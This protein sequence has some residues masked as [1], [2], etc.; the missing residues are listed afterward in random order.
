LNVRR[1]SILNVA[2]YYLQQW[3]FLESYSAEN[4]ELPDPNITTSA[5]T[6]CAVCTDEE[7]TPRYYI[8]KSG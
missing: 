1:G 3:Q 6:R 7:K 4:I 2:A 8:Q 5:H